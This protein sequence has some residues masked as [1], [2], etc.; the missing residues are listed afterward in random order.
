MFHK[1]YAHRDAMHSRMRRIKTG[2]AMLTS[3][4]TNRVRPT[5]FPAGTPYRAS[6]RN[7]AFSR[8]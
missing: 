5:T 7:T 8:C 4:G 2:Q 3:V 6:F 1:C